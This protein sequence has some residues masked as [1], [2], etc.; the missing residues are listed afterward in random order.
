MERKL[1][2]RVGLMIFLLR[3]LPVVPLS[4]ISAAAGVLRLKMAPFVLWTL[5]G[6]V[7]RCLLLGYLGY[8]T[9]DAY[10]GMAGRLNSVETLMSG[11][12][13]VAAFAVIF[14]LR[15]RLSKKPSPP[16]G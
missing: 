12:I 9:R 14:W 3:A 4:L 1:E 13:V 7:P 11:T 2:G 15:H 10:K 5:I 8:F 16:Q 6:S